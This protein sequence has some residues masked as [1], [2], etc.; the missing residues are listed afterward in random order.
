[1]CYLLLTYYSAL[2]SRMFFLYFLLF[3]FISTF[4]H[5]TPPLGQTVFQERPQ[6]KKVAIIGGGAAGSST[7]FWLSNTIGSSIPLHITVYEKEDRVGGRSMT[8]PIKGDP[9]L[10]HIELGASIFVPVNYNMMNASERFG[11]PLKHLTAETKLGIWNGESFLFEETGNQYWDTAKMLWRYGTAPLRFPNHLRSILDKFLSVYDI[12]DRHEAFTTLPQILDQLNMKALVNQSASDH[13]NDMFGS[14][15]VHELVQSASRGNYGQDVDYLHAFAALVSMSAGSGAWSLQDGN[16]RIF[17]EFLARS[18]HTQLRLNTKVT[19]IESIHEVDEHNHSVQQYKI[20]TSQSEE[21]ELYDAVVLASPLHMA[22]IDLPCLDFPEHY[23]R[24]YH[25]V[26]VTIIAGYPDPSYFGRNEENVPTSIITTGI[27]L[28]DH[29]D[30]QEAPFTTFTRHLTLDNGESVVKMFSSKELSD[31]DIAA[32]FHN[33][34]WIY[35]KSWQAFPKLLPVPNH[36]T[37][38][39]NDWPPVILHDFDTTGGGLFYANAFENVISTMET[40]TLMGKNIARLIHERW[41]LNP[42]ES[43]PSLHSKCAPF[44]DGWGNY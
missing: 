41:C 39:G 32:L 10:G 30:H 2:H 24:Q 34:S 27:P 4:A 37:E 5:A 18:K 36:S 38:N 20:H 8:I 28:V 44:G 1:M 29:F 7:A 35:R 26:H 31:N 16:Y 33:T 22:N 23:A 19:S 17:E 43:S 40:Q 14:I 25:T 11:L 12:D 6:L 9:T 42:T 13:L 3:F 15:F 21:G